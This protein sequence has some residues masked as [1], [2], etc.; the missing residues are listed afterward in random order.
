LDSIGEGCLF[1]V[2]LPQPQ[3][4][5]TKDLTEEIKLVKVMSLRN[6]LNWVNWDGEN[7]HENWMAPVLVWESWIAWE[8]GKLEVG[9]LLSFLCFWPRMWCDPP[10][11]LKCLPWLLC[12]NGL[13]L[14]ICELKQT[15]SSLS[16]LLSG[17]FITATEMK[18][19]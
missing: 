16:Y 14:R 13:Q 5:W 1:I 2:N 12:Y 11:Y 4:T 3:T 10:P 17:Y 9:L 18:P 7:K 15:F 6:V 19:G 8:L